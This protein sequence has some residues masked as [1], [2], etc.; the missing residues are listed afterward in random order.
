MDIGNV[1]SMLKLLIQEFEICIIKMVPPLFKL[2]RGCFVFKKRLQLLDE[3]D[4]DLYFNDTLSSL[5]KL[6]LGTWKQVLKIVKSSKPF[7][8]R[9]LKK[10]A[11]VVLRKLA[12][13]YVE[14]KQVS[15][16]MKLLIK[17]IEAALDDT[18][19]CLK[20]K[21]SWSESLNLYILIAG[22]TRANP[23]SSKCFL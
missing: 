4:I 9:I 6:G 3:E 8:G 5:D 23:S 13:D 14:K 11:R 7:D 15:E 21:H 19:A 22:C 2:F 10:Q 1:L 16:K 18:K 17:N 20:R 12:G